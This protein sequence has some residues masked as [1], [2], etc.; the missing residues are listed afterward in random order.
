MYLTSPLPLP[1]PY[2][3][4][5]KG[6]VL[7]VIRHSRRH[8]NYM[9]ASAWHAC[10]TAYQLQPK[11]RHFDIIFIGRLTTFGD[12]PW[13]QFCQDVDISVTVL[14]RY[15]W[16]CVRPGPES[17]VT[18]LFIVR[19]VVHVEGTSSF[20]CHWGGDPDPS[21]VVNHSVGV[22]HT[23]HA[24]ISAGKSWWRHQME[25]FSALLAFVRGIHRSPVNS[26]HKGQWR[27]ALGF[28]LICAPTDG[29]V[30]NQDTGDLRRQRALYD[31]TVILSEWNLNGQCTQLYFFNKK[32]RTHKKLRKTTDTEISQMSELM[33]CVLLNGSGDV[34]NLKVLTK[35]LHKSAKWLGV[36]NMLCHCA[37]MY[38]S[39]LL[40][41]H[42]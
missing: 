10:F 18:S 38:R 39:I 32:N 3:Y 31:V 13:Q 34:P 36:I 26:P 19:E 1:V 11:C 23:H 17:E 7:D 33:Q 4:I 27:G 25:T 12:Q 28:S 37:H 16:R 8:H 20:Q 30:N 22:H 41:N 35:L 29:W 21:C 40:M 5:P 42:L 24:V 6:S 15:L 14:Q 2:R 9:Y